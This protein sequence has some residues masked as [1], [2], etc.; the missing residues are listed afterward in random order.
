MPELK[1]KRT[2]GEGDTR[3]SQAFVVHARENMPT[4]MHTIL[5]FLCQR[6][7]CNVLFAIRCFWAKN[8]WTCMSKDTTSLHSLVWSVQ[9]QRVLCVN[10]G[11]SVSNIFLHRTKCFPDGQSPEKVTCLPCQKTFVTKH[12][13]RTVH[14]SVRDCNVCGQKVKDLERH[15]QNMHGEQEK[16]N[17]CQDCGK[18]FKTKL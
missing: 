16:S 9:K 3:L 13:E 1:L 11:A 8:F 10:C 7:P 6:L 5:K 2:L 12:H 14:I 18:E 4:W 15:K 17:K